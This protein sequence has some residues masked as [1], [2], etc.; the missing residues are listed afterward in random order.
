MNRFYTERV[1]IMD[2]HYYLE[3]SA[4]LTTATN[5]RDNFVEQS[6]KT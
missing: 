6:E 2:F 1:L 5:S 4:N 3:T